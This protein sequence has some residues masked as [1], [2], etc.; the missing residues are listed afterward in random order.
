M[1]QFIKPKRPVAR[2]FLHC[3]A[4]DANSLAYQGL[5]LVKTIDEWHKARNFDGIGYHYVIDKQG[6]VMNGRNLERV[7]AAQKGYNS[8]SIA[9]CLHGLIESKF[10]VEQREAL[11]DLCKQI[12]SAYNGS[13]TFHGHCEVD[14]FKTCPVVDYKKWLGLNAFGR[15]V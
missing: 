13:I 10:R 11:L 14:K 5:N 4:S 1:I 6:R 7:P 8:G 15:M 3:T 12:K 9:I 2:V